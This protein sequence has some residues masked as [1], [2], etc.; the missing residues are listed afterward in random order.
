V[1]EISEVESEVDGT[2]VESEADV[3]LEGEV[4]AETVE[5]N[6]DCWHERVGS[7]H[8]GLLYR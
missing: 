3:A 8:D 2:G 5:M 7:G 6:A 1:G 4:E